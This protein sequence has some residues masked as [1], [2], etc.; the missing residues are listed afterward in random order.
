M[1]DKTNV[2]GSERCGKKTNNPF[3]NFL[4]CYRTRADRQH[5]SAMEN[6][7]QGARE[8]NRMNEEQRKPFVE[9]AKPFL[10][11]ESELKFPRR[12]TVGRKVRRRRRSRARSGVKMARRGRRS[13][14]RSR[15]T[16]RTVK[17]RAT[18]RR[19]RT[20]TSRRRRATT[21]RTRRKTMT[22]RRP[23]SRASTSRSR[24]KRMTQSSTKAYTID[25]GTTQL[26]TLAP[27]MDSRRQ[28]TLPSTCPRPTL[29]YSAMTTTT[30]TPAPG[31]SPETPHPT[32]SACDSKNKLSKECDQSMQGSLHEVTYTTSKS[33]SDCGSFG[34]LVVVDVE[35]AANDVSKNDCFR[36]DRS[37][38]CCIPPPIDSCGG[39]GSQMHVNCNCKQIDELFRKNSKN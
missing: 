13:T 29:P 6:A 20:A 32:E 35:Q 37:C 30:T 10:K 39:T 28:S 16:R 12:S 34:H 36:N 18:S 22:K 33:S 27:E 26:P 38:P 1:D 7:V 21:S 19:R 25:N 2:A 3:F 31:M 9:M 14:A 8:W 15:S 11:P 24:A 4:R 23:R 5:K 17:S